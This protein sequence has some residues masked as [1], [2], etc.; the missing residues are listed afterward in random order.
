MPKDI[1]AEFDIRLIK[2]NL[3]SE[4]FKE[5]IE[6]DAVIVTE[7]NYLLD[8]K[9]FNGK[10]LVVDTWHGFPLKAMGFVDKGEKYKNHINRVWENVDIIASYSKLFNCVMNQCINADPNKYVITGAP[11]NDFLY[12][13]DGKEMLSRITGL[14]LADKNKRILLY[15]PTYR[16][17]SRGNRHDGSRKW[18]NIFDMPNFDYN[19]FSQ[20]LRQNGLVLFVKLHPA[21]ESVVID[22]IQ[23]N[24]NIFILRGEM[25][26]K[27]YVDLYEIVSAAD[28][29]ITDYSSIYFDYLLLDRPIIFTPIDLDE[30]E[31]TRGLLLEPYD[32]WTPGPK[33]FDQECLEEQILKNLAHQKYYKAERE[34]L[35][36]LVHFYKDSMSAERVWEVIREKL[37]GIHG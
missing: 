21:E 6:S 3:S 8:K 5:I 37:T 19:T 4:Y 27:N 33:V 20:F 30:Y 29:L 11:R 18:S 34:H 36:D 1:K 26:E 12:L 9:K 15:M 22:N 35:S 32:R 7:G 10:Q 28:L 14:D 23:E 31:N 16:F 25:L 13:S 2:Q 24:E 17:T